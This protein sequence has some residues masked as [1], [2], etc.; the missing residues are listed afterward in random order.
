[1]QVKNGWKTA[2]IEEKLD[3]IN[4]LEKDKRI[5]YIYCNVRPA[6]VSVRI[7]CGNADRITENSKSGTKVFVYQDYHSSIRINGNKKCGC[8]LHSYWIRKKYII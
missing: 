6:R 7:I 1:M 2:G 8:L 4:W 5:V 3:V